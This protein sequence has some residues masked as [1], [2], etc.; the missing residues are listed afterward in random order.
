MIVA[1]RDQASLSL[2]CRCQEF[3]GIG[4]LGSRYLSERLDKDTSAG[5]RS[6]DEESMSRDQDHQERATIRKRAGET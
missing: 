3:H 6:R 2:P 1:L 4:F 5:E